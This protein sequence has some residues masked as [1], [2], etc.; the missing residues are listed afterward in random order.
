MSGTKNT[1]QS[2]DFLK[3]LITQL[4]QQDPFEP[5]KNTEFIGQMA[6]LTSLESLHEINDNIGQLVKVQEQYK[7]K[8]ELLLAASLLGRGVEAKD[9]NTGEVYKGQVK[10]FYLQNGE[11]R[12][13]LDGRAISATWVYKATG[14]IEEDGGEQ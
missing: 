8:S 14:F 9:P 13:V 1:L 5:V 12:F 4:R 6:Q 2:G 10:G 3:L 11:I 7:I